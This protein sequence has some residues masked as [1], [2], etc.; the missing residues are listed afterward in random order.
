MTD[1]EKKFYE[2]G[3]KINRCVAALP[4]EAKKV[5]ASEEGKNE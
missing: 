3:M 1:Y 5:S 2:Q 4:A